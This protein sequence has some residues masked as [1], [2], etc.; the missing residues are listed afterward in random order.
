MT[1]QHDGFNIIV[2]ALQCI[3][4]SPGTAEIQ[5]IVDHDCRFV[6]AEFAGDVPR[7]VV[8]AAVGRT[9]NDQIRA[10]TLFGQASAH[11]G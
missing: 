11:V 9:G 8:R 1:D 3:E 7:A 5:F 6:E 4:H 10:V 2:H